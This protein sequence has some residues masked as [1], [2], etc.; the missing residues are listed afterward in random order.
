MCSQ[1]DTTTA[2]PPLLLFCKPNTVSTV[3]DLTPVIMKPGNMN[4]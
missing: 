4:G 3:A 2:N 1:E